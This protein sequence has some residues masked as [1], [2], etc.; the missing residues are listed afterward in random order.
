MVHTVN[1]LDKWFKA[2]NGYPGLQHFKKGILSESQWTGTKHKE[3]EKI[4]LG[5][6]I[7]SIPSCFIHIVCSLVDF[8]YLSQLQLHTS[9]MLNSLESCLKTFHLHKNIVI[10]H[11][12]QD[13]FNILKLHALLHYIDCICSLG[14]ADG[15]NTESPERLHID[16]VKDAYHASN[17]RDYVKQMAI[18]LQRHEATHPLASI[19]S[20]IKTNPNLSRKH[21]S[22]LV[23][24][25]K[26]FKLSRKKLEVI[27]LAMQCPPQ[28]KRFTIKV[29]GLREESIK[30]EKEDKAD[31]KVLSDGS[32][33]SEELEQ[34]LYSTVK[35]SSLHSPS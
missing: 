35:I 7:G 27:Y 1:E 20:S 5:I 15:Y 24:L 18:W 9:T 34:Q 32:G 19:V 31:F 4:L 30:W 12:I 28:Q 33:N 2:M 14:S 13:H 17:K 25:I 8:I 3:M 11:G 29:T 26:V 22:P 6:A 16:Y 21:A 10:E 23:N